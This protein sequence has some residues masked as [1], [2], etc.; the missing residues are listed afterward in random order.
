MCCSTNASYQPLNALTFPCLPPAPRPA[1]A[2]C[3]TN[4]SYQRWDEARK[5]W[6]LIVNRSRDVTRQALGYIPS[7][8]PDLQDMFCRWV[9]AYRW[10][11]ISVGWPSLQVARHTGGW[12]TG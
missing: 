8:Q 5:M 6:G 11:E 7:S 2:P 10:V 9:I 3:S 4:T 1:P 12:V